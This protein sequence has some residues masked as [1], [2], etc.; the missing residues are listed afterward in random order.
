VKRLAESKEARAVEV[1]FMNQVSGSDKALCNLLGHHPSQCAPKR[2][3]GAKGKLRSSSMDNL[4]TF[5][6]R[7]KKKTNPTFE[8]NYAQP[9]SENKRVA[10]ELEQVENEVI[11]SQTVLPCLWSIRP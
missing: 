7:S 5:E 2:S 10:A 1:A 4:S 11:Q 3:I 8:Y 6:S 9:R